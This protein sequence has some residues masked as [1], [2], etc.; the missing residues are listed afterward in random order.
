MIRPKV[1]WTV[2]H[3]PGPRLFSSATNTPLL[4]P[5]S[6]HPLQLEFY[7]SKSGIPQPAHILAYLAHQ[8]LPM[9]FMARVQHL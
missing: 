9:C 5:T 2:S 6:H 4:I 1:P 3:S 7:A 8:L